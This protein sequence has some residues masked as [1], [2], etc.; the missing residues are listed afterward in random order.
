MNFQRQLQVFAD[1]VSTVV[2]EDAGFFGM[3]KLELVLNH[4][5]IAEKKII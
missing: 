1:F 4:Y 5:Q 2:C 3:S